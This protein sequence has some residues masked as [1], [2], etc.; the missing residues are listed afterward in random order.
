MESLTDP[1]LFKI[2]LDGAAGAGKSAFLQRHLNCHFV[3]EYTP[4]ITNGSVRLP[5]NTSIGPIV[6]D[7]WELERAYRS[8]D[9]YDGAHG[10]IAMYD[11]S[12]PSGASKNYA[13]KAVHGHPGLAS[14][15]C[16]N[17]KDIAVKNELLF[18]R[19]PGAANC[20]VSNKG[21]TNCEK[22]FLHLAR[23]LT[24][25]PGLSF[26]DPPCTKPIADGQVCPVARQGDEDV[27][28]LRYHLNPGYTHGRL[29]EMFRDDD[30]ENWLA[31][32][33]FEGKSVVLCITAVALT[34]I[35]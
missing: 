29:A 1:P 5:F 30:L 3:E 11:L 12:D 28:M 2:V 18:I 24:N 20:E 17:K 8:H 25:M 34:K 22:P 13:L 21:A 15:L 27:Q 14:V 33:G 32:R 19:V 6:F 26:T 31:E 4:T 10:L 23:R 9:C 35:G 7:V 16:G